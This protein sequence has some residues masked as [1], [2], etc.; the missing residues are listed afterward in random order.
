MILV[1]TQKKTHIIIAPPQFV[2]TCVI[3]KNNN[4]NGFIKYRLLMNNVDKYIDD[5]TSNYF[6]LES[7]SKPLRT[8]SYY[9]KKDLDEIAKYFGLTF[10]AKTKK[11]DVYNRISEYIVWK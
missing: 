6:C 5:I 4:M 3:H 11:E 2:K 1:D 9:K 10:D 8:I 7:Y